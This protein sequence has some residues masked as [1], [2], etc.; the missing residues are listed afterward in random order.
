MVQF[1]IKSSS[2]ETAQLVL[3]SFAVAYEKQG[4]SVVVSRAHYP[5]SKKTF[6]SELYGLIISELEYR[7]SLEVAGGCF[8]INF[9][10]EHE[11]QC[12]AVPPVL[13]LGCVA[14]VGC[15][16]SCLISSLLTC[17]AVRVIWML[18]LAQISIYP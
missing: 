11:L 12:C 14:N 2:A 17:T 9:P 16:C 3:V 10:T 15:L 5:F 13:L 1:I 4:T 18:R 7:Q 6:Y 8:A